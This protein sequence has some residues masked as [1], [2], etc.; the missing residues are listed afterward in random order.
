MRVPI[1]ARRKRVSSTEGSQCRERRKSIDLLPFIGVNFTFELAGLCS[2]MINED[3]V[4]SR[5]VIS[6]S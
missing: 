6:R 2:A 1:C 4:I 5:F 3:F